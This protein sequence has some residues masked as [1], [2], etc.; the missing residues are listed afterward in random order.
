VLWRCDS[1]APTDIPKREKQSGTAFQAQLKRVGAIVLSTAPD[2]TLKR[3]G[4]KFH[5]SVMNEPYIDVSHFGQQILLCLG[6]IP[7]LI[8]HCKQAANHQKASEPDQY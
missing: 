7:V 4:Y 1:R 2:G 8:V 6:H 5:A 3:G